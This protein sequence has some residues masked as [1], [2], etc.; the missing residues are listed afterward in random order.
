M[1]KQYEGCFLL[2]S[3]IPKEE[4]EKEIS[5]IE[6]TIKK[7]GGEIIKKEPWGTKRLA[8]PIKKNTDAFYYLFF[9]KAS[10]DMILPID[11]FLKRRESILRYLFLER[12]KLP[13]ERKKQK[14]E[15][16]PSKKKS[17]EE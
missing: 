17:K 4:T 15:S 14:S 6:E 9:F 8:Y 13:R 16:H 5:F 11:L 10:P 1:E 2:K 12:K 7:N 3:S